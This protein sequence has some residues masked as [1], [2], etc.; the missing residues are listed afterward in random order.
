MWFPKLFEQV[1]EY[2]KTCDPGCTSSLPAVNRETSEKPWGHYYSR[3]QGTLMGPQGQLLPCTG[4]YIFK[5]ARGG[6][7]Y[8]NGPPYNSA[9][10]R[11][12]AMPC[13]PEHPQVNGLAE[14]MM[15]SIVKLTHVSLAKG[16]I[17]RQRSHSGCSTKGKHPFPLQ[18]DS[19]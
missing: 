19:Q 14:K 9:E 8:N 4:G 10:L 1:M 2:I 17:L 7:D 6:S 5:V 16:R 13:T 18:E 12:Y 11:R 15:T 3:L